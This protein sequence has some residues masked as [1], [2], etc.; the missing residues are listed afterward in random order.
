MENR[1]KLLTFCSRIVGIICILFILVDLVD[2]AFLGSAILF[3]FGA[4]LL[5][6]VFAGV[7]RLPESFLCIYFCIGLNIVVCVV[8]MLE[9]DYIACIPLFICA[10]T[11]SAIFFDTKLV[12]VSFSASILLYLLEMAGLSLLAGNFII[13]PFVMVECVLAMAVCFFLVHCCVSNGLEYMARSDA[14][15]A[16]SQELLQTVNKQIE[17]VKAASAKSRR[18]LEEVHQ[19]S[20]GILEGTDRLTDGS[21]ALASGAARQTVLVGELGE[22]IQTISSKIKETADY[23]GNVRVEADEMSVNVDT[24]SQKMN[25]MLAAMEEIHKSSLSIEKIIKAIEDIA[26]QTNILALNAAIEAARAGAAGKGFAV[27]ADEVRSLAAK[28]AQAAGS[29][30]ELLGTCLASINHGSEIASETAAALERIGNSVNE[31]SSKTYLISDM[32]NGQTSMVGEINSKIAQVSDVIQ[33]I[34]GTAEE[35]E[36]AGLE[37]QKQA[38]RLEHMCESI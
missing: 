24:G 8:T 15:E 26:F 10:G 25:D 19:A 5:V 4:G 21:A 2:G 29:T 22:T 32:T 12:K 14:N 28:S 9:K 23:A 17:E 27:V 18:I 33:T 31:V 6:P 20:A 11:I 36:A 3:L 37:F 7:G 38:E 1:I 16:K 34:A 30:T 13:E 35:T